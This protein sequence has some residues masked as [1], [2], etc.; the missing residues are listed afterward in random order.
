MNALGRVCRRRTFASLAG[1]ALACLVT[2]SLAHAADIGPRRGDYPAYGAGPIIGGL[3]ANNGYYAY[4]PYYGPGYGY[5]G[6]GP[7]YYGPAYAYNGPGYYG[8]PYWRHRYWHR[9]YW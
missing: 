5:Y 8:G 7:D 6:Y 2:A 1:A 9:H 3:A 4:G